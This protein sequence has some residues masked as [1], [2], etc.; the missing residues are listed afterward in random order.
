MNN[1]VNEEELSQ[2]LALIENYKEQLNSLQN[3]YSYLQAAVADYL[4][5]KLT[6]EHMQKTEEGTEILIPIGG[7]SYINASMR[8]TSK[9]LVDV[10][11]NV[12]MD[13]TIDSAIKKINDRIEKLQESQ[14][15]ISTL[16]QKLESEATEI[17]YKAQQLM[18]EEKK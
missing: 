7:N 18:S 15:K 5:A 4:K 1:M 12:V 2:Y 13:M 6:L 14:E 17:S 16:T 8:N 11:A 3:Q 10:G 9:I